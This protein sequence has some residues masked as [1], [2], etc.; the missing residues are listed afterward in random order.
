MIMIILNPNWSPYWTE[1]KA[2]CSG[3]LVGDVFQAVDRG[4]N[5]RN[6]PRVPVILYSSIIQRLKITRSKAKC[7]LA[8]NVNERKKMLAAWILTS[9][10]YQVLQ[11]MR[12]GLANYHMLHCSSNENDPIYN[13]L[14]D[15]HFL[16]TTNSLNI[17]TFF[18]GWCMCPSGFAHQL[19]H[20]QSY[21]LY[22]G[23][24]Y[25]WILAFGVVVFSH[26]LGRCALYPEVHC[27]PEIMVYM[28]IK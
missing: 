10:C 24:A 18:C 5:P 11:H 26:I 2:A 17:S 4:H 13:V 21:A 12:I 7:V 28:E 3:K 9:S 8:L 20:C 25:L 14:S 23:A 22:S 6:G 16:W 19:W 1:T 15:S 27:S